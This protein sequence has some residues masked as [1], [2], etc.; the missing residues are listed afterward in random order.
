MKA[1]IYFLLSGIALADLPRMTIEHGEKRQDLRVDEVEVTVRVEGDFVE[2]RMSLNFFNETHLNQEGEFRLPLPEGASV[3]H[4]AL[5]VNGKMREATV[6]EKEQ[7]LRAYETI[8]A[9][10]ID[11]GL[12]E[13]MENNIYRTRIFP[14]LPKQGKR[15]SIGYVQPLQKIKDELVYRLPF[16]VTENVGKFQLK[17]EGDLADIEP[18]LTG[19]MK[20]KKE[21]N[22]YSYASEN[23]SVV[24]DLVLKRESKFGGFTGEIREVDGESFAYVTGSIRR[25]ADELKAR[26]PKII[27]VI[28]DASASGYSRDIAK[29]IEFLDK[30]L[31]QLGDVTVQ[32]VA[33]HGE[34]E[35]LGEFQVK[36]GD[37]KKLRAAADGIFY[38]GAADWR[39]LDFK[40]LN[41]ERVILFGGGESAFPISQV[42]LAE[43]FQVIRSG[44]AETETVFSEMAEKSGGGV[45][46]LTKLKVA[47][48]MTKALETKLHVTG[49]DG[50]VE[51]Y[52]SEIVDGQL[53]VF[54]KMKTI[55][56]EQLVLSLKSGSGLTERITVLL[57]RS[58]GGNA[59]RYFWAQRR[60]EEMSRQNSVITGNEKAAI[61]THCQRYGL[62]SDFTSLIVL[63]RMEDHIEFRIPP[64]EPEL[65]EDYQRGIEREEQS[66]KKRE[67]L[68]MLKFLWRN[69]VEWYET[70][71]PWMEVALL[72]RYERVKKWTDAQTSVFEKEQIAQ[73]N[74]AEFLAWK[75]EAEKLMREMD[76][77]KTHQTF[78][79]WNLKIGHLLEK[80]K[81]LGEKDVEL[82]INGEIGVSVR[83]LVNQPQTLNL[84]SGTMLREAI[85]KA[86]G[87]HASGT[88]ARVA[89]YRSGKRSIYNL[90][91]KNYED[92]KLLPGDMVVVMSDYSRGGFD[93]PFAAG[94]S[95]GASDPQRHE[96]EPVLIEGN[97]PLVNPSPKYELSTESYEDG[98]PLSL[99]AGGGLRARRGLN[100]LPELPELQGA[101]RKVDNIRNANQERVDELSKAGDFW[102]AY[103]KD[104]PKTGNEV[105]YFNA[106]AKELYKRN[107]IKKAR[108]VLSNLFAPHGFHVPSFRATAYWMMEF[109]DYEGAMEIF[110]MIALKFPEDALL[111]F[112]VMRLH[113]IAEGAIP[114]SRSGKLL[115]EET[116]KALSDP[117]H[118]VVA[119]MV[120][121]E[122]NRF[123][124]K[125]FEGIINRLPNESEAFSSD[126]RVVVTCS[127]SVNR[128]YMQISEPTDTS[129]ASND[130]SLTGGR[131]VSGK[132]VAE[133]M[134]RRAMPGDY[135]LE[136]ANLAGGTYQVEIFLNWCRPNETR[137]MFTLSGGGK[138]KM[139]DAGV[140]N[141]NF[142]KQ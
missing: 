133:F 66:R 107:E 105:T 80:G 134:I 83:G 112:D 141:F 122:R 140:V 74:I 79:D 110:E 38:D 18:Q 37:W 94:G 129:I 78:L 101:V 65:M 7:A 104:R 25:E 76:Q 3:N 11:P 51:S 96:N 64:P 75:D 24:G 30:L 73:T 4:Y 86:G 98:E 17:I 31:G 71:F 33:V 21:D 10:N 32:L 43:N 61:I 59:L 132:G 22:G 57:K 135:R 44:A 16:G 121:M 91:S 12:V 111:V 19:G 128:T 9:R 63:E 127:D 95:F 89:I 40:E 136:L 15:V 118:A 126:I 49:V 45:I 142:G 77:I 56:Q 114:G 67:Q 60:L 120:M 42:K 81:K 124:A 39:K 46:D 88:E 100:D 48:A 6:V 115:G 87:V 103:R 69:R 138:E 13:K 130:I 20:L 93:D 28:W 55:D 113:R 2:T 53:R 41:G 47:D 62:V 36:G 26:K 108:R 58:E 72:P 35:D 27:T 29:E 139:I 116:A 137:Q 68:G 23:S 123:K 131:S 8:K 90:L 14:V 1:L 84:K 54:A 125:H 106:V 117:N 85:N 99:S 50:A 102:E 34:V 52:F 119:E 92:I 70:K 97:P 109:K 5:E 82:P